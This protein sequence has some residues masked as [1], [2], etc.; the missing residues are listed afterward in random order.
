MRTLGRVKECAI[1]TCAGSESQ[2]LEGMIQHSFALPLPEGRWPFDGWTNLERIAERFNSDKFRARP[3]GELVDLGESPKAKHSPIAKAKLTTHDSFEM[4]LVDAERPPVLD[5]AGQRSELSKGEFEEPRLVFADRYDHEDYASINDFIVSDRPAPQDL[6]KISQTLLELMAHERSRLFGFPLANRFVNVLLPHAILQPHGAVSAAKNAWFMQPLVS[7]I[8]GGRDRGRLRNTY[9]LT[10]FLVPVVL[11]GRELKSRPMAIDEIDHVVN[12]GW[13]F[14]AAPRD[15]LSPKFDMSDQLLRY[16]SCL[17]RFDLR[18]MNWPFQPAREMPKTYE[19]LT[20]RQAVERAAFGVDLS[21]AQGKAGKADLETTRHIGNDVITALGSARVSSVVVVDPDLTKC[22]V[23]KPKKDEPYP[24]QLETLMKTLA[25]SVRVPERSDE[26]ASRLRLD[27]P[28][29]DGKT[30]AIG[31]LPVRRCIVVLS[32][33]DEQHG[34]EESAL[35]QAGSIAYMTI[36]A[37]MATGALRQIDRRLEYQEDAQHPKKIAE[38]DAEIAS[39]LGEIYDLDITR[40]PYREV[41]RLLRKQLGITRDYE[42]LQSKMEALF[43]ATSTIHEDN[44][45]RLLLWLTVVTTI[46]TVLAVIA[47]VAKG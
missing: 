44:Q 18:E 27:S 24:G 46:L 40:E 37:A 1:A 19:P 35:M 9:V 34:F 30:Y 13:G 39:D 26:E 17:A 29:V 10:F 25:G 43:R 5:W 6:E 33:K 21:V 31:V 15:D 7:F 32:C 16:L 41:Y 38:I 42:I 20:I 3:L 14:A 45:Q 2:T 22:Q 36:G 4:T 28:A 12:P 11:D 8:R 23:R 47:T